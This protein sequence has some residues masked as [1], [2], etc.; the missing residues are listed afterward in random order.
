MIRDATEDD[1]PEILAMGRKFFDLAGWSEVAEWDDASV[2]A[3]L[4]HLMGSDDGILLVIDDGAGRITGMAG[5]LLYPF[6]LNIKHRTGQE[7]FWWVEPEARGR[8]ALELFDAL[9]NRARGQGAMSFAMITVE[10]L[11]SAA[12]GRYYRRR[13]YRAAE[14]TY[15]KFSL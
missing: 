6:Y 1:I 2:T 10:G 7:L 12:L 14:T 5:A 9:E 15:I 8:E 13:G 11:R 4:N 3:T